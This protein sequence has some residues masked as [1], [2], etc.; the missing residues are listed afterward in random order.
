[1]VSMVL[2]YILLDS[3]IPQLAEDFN[4]SLYDVVSYSTYLL[5]I[6]YDTFYFYYINSVQ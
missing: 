1:M 5:Y 6:K 4:L 2:P 3:T